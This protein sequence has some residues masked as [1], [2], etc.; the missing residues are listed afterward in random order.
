[1]VITGYRYGVRGK[2]TLFILSLMCILLQ[3]LSTESHQ[4]ECRQPKSR[5]IQVNI[6]QNVTIVLPNIAALV[7]RQILLWAFNY[8]DG[9]ELISG[10]AYQKCIDQRNELRLEIKPEGNQSVVIASIINVQPDSLGEHVFE[11]HENTTFLCNI[12]MANLF[13]QRPE[14]TS[15]FTSPLSFKSDFTSTPKVHHNFE[16][17]QLETI[18]IAV[19]SF[20]VSGTIIVTILMV[21]CSCVGRKAYT[22]E[23]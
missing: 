14:E 6:G 23:K 3:V 9:K 19:A 15:F 8:H 7:P 18:F 12:L 4:T 20:V 1:M 2:P 13:V 21:L 5:F 22:M 11:L 10:C 16:L 17:S